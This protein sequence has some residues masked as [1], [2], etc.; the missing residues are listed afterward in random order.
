LSPEELDEI[1]GNSKQ[2]EKDEKIDQK[3]LKKEDR[4]RKNDI[5]EVR[6]VENHEEKEGK[7]R[8]IEK[9]I[10]IKDDTLE[11]K[12]K[13]E[14]VK[15]EKV[16]LKE[17]A[18]EK[19][20]NV[21]ENAKIQTFDTEPKAE[22][23]LKEKKHKKKDNPSEKV[24]KELEESPEIPSKAS[25]ILTKNEKTHILPQ[26]ESPK[27]QPASHS[28]PNPPTTSKKQ[29][30]IPYSPKIPTQN[31]NKPAEIAIEKH[32][33]PILVPQPIIKT[34]EIHAPL[35]DYLKYEQQTRVSVDIDIH[36]GLADS[37]SSD[38]APVEV[39]ISESIDSF[40]PITSL[41]QSIPNASSQEEKIVLKEIQAGLPSS[42]ESACCAS[43]EVF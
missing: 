21:I 11:I 31:D 37:S 33:D 16:V 27:P 24:T 20:E 22:K 15:Q 4:G 2:E 17:K 6:N 1:T 39:D 13:Y 12:D 36:K 23:S 32:K 29:D 43:C 26:A 5:E 34:E 30:P 14:E 35:P 3:E 7:D 8:Q 38:E 19:N 42:R 40:M 41:K 9:Q 10:E 18:G 28:S 25:E